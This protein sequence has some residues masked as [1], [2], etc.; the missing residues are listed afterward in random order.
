MRSI[1]CAALL[2]AASAH[3]AERVATQ[4]KDEARISDA[5]C[6][7]A[8]VLALIDPAGHGD[9]RRAVTRFQGQTYEACWRV[10]G[11]Y[12]HLVYEDGDQGAIALEDFKV[13]ASI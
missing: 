5:P 10:V 7:N 8:A 9:F 6:T 2:C 12:A 4:G 1:L 13:P 3:A 11:G